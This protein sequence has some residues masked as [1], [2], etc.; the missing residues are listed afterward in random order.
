MPIEPLYELANQLS[1]Q[2]NFVEAP[3]AV[4][5]IDLGKNSCSIA[6]LDASGAVVYRRRMTR[7]SIIAF[8]ATLPSCIP[9]FKLQVDPTRLKRDFP[10]DLSAISTCRPRRKRWVESIISEFEHQ[11]S[12]LY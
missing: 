5:G 10:R 2:R 12:D 8:T 9:E 7:D 1:R 3:I 4:L 11:V 6:G